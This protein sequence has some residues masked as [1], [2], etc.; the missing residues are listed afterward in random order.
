MQGLLDRRDVIDATK[1]TSCRVVIWPKSVP[2][3][4]TD[5][6]ILR[7]RESWSIVLSVFTTTGPRRK[8]RALR[9]GKGGA[10]M[11]G[12]L[13]QP[14]METALKDLPPKLL[15]QEAAALLRLEVTTLY[16]HVSEGRYNGTVKRGNPKGA[17][18]VIGGI[19]RTC[20][21]RPGRQSVSGREAAS[22]RLASVC[23]HVP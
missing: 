23:G 15:Q 8:R 3:Q 14:E 12:K 18:H 13:T 7:T 10:R 4:D 19:H 20:V 17:P 22:S 2:Q 9:D 21:S 1:D 6:G 5:E 11:N 16:R